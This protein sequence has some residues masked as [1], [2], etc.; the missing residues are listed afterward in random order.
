MVD[1]VMEATVEES[2]FKYQEL[3]GLNIKIM[4]NARGPVKSFL[5]KSA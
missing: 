4:K 2:P 1:V 3:L 5:P